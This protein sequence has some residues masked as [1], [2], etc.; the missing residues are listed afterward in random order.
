V[1]PNDQSDE[2]AT[3]LAQRA[4]NDANARRVAVSVAATCRDIEDALTPIVG[5]RGVAA[6]LSRSVHVAGQTHVWLNEIKEGLP[7]AIDLQAL[8]ALLARQS[9]AT[10]A[11]CGG[12]LLHSFH[13]LLVSLIGASLTERL[14]RSAWAPFMSSRPQDFLP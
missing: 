11:A 6:L 8:T 7:A 12:L 5:T 13:E 3:F 10:A 14:L 9:P 2:I 1:V 4:G